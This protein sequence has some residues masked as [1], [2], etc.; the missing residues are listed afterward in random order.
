LAISDVR[1]SVAATATDPGTG[2]V[3]ATY[4]GIQS[5]PL[6]GGTVGAGYEYAFTTWI[7]AKVEYLHF[8]LGRS[9]YPVGVPPLGVPG[10][11]TATTR[12]SGDIVRVGVNFLLHE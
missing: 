5:A 6:S 3:V 10:V 12:F 8:E 2:K 7:S 4:A 11:W 1:S 9:N